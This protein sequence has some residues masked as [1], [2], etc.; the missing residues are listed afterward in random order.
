MV[1]I[2]VSVTR[3]DDDTERTERLSRVAAQLREER[4]PVLALHDR[5]DL[6]GTNWKRR[7]YTGEVDQAM[8]ICAAYGADRVN[9]YIRGRLLLSDTDRDVSRR[10][11]RL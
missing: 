5:L 3:G 1:D 10:D 8:R 6:L 9:H 7:P 11:D 4:L 2:K